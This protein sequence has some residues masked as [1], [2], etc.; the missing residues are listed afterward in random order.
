MCVACYSLLNCDK[1]NESSNAILDEIYALGE[2][3]VS[4]INNGGI[5]SAIKAVQQA[6]TVLTVIHYK[7]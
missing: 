5:A 2:I 1:T 7:I 3:V 4:D 6:R